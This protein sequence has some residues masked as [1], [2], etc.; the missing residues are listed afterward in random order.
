[1]SQIIEV[2]NEQI[3]PDAMPI[4]IATSVEEVEK[5]MDEN[6]L[7]R[8]YV[9]KAGRCMLVFVKSQVNFAKQVVVSRPIFGET[10]NISVSPS[11]NDE[12]RFVEED[13]VKLISETHS[14]ELP[15]EEPVNQEPVKEESLPPAK[16]GRW[17][18]PTPL[19][20]RK[21]VRCKCIS[22]SY[23]GMEG[24]VEHVDHE[25]R[26]DSE[27][28]TL[29][30]T[31]SDLP[32]VM[33]GSQG[34]ANRSMMSNMRMVPVHGVPHK[35]R[36]RWLDPREEETVQHTE[37]EGVRLSSKTVRAPL[38]SKTLTKAQFCS[39]FMIWVEE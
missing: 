16:S 8:C 25:G 26:P 18:K 29:V 36:V 9:V 1:M 21:G 12:V 24:I 20:I 4:G 30:S 11:L 19:T 22:G 17:V 10:P 39:D 23:A 3:K 27:T 31:N 28:H 32:M 38:V 33:Q 15:K 34:T 13:S 37:V 14:T 5:I 2:S 7:A 6:D 35:V